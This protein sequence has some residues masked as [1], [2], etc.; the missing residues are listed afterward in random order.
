MWGHTAWTD[1]NV[2]A[3]YTD[4]R[5]PL[6]MSFIFIVQSS[7]GA[8]IAARDSRGRTPFLWAPASNRDVRALLE[9]R[10]VCVVVGASLAVTWQEQRRLL[11][12]LAVGSCRLPPG[13]VCA[14]IV[15]VMMPYS[16]GEN[17][18]HCP[19]HHVHRTLPL[20]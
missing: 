19:T 9:F 7:P 3:T 1:A 14:H 12:M 6:H 18:K 11:N 16:P 17:S 8:D 4:G 13:R 20:A 10:G 15:M 2:E 5:T